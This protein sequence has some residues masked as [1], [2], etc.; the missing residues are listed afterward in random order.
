MRLLLI[1]FALG[2]VGCEEGAELGE[3]PASS[4]AQQLAGRQVVT[5]ACQRCH[6]SS[7]TGAAREDAPDDMNFDDL[8]TVREE[9]ESM[10]GQILEG[11]M[12]PTGALSDADAES[13]RV[14][15]AC[16]AQDVQQP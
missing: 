8:A 2:L 13:V 5:V 7:K 4:D 16:G 12:P 15:L 3:C 1:L 6:D 14:W 10:Y 9:G 11:E